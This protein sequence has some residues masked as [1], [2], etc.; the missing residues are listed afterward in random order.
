MVIKIETMHTYCLYSSIHL[1][2]LRIIAITHSFFG[3]KVISKI[4]PY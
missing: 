4:L 2:S 3:N 1:H